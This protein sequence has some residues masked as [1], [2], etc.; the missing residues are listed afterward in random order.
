MDAQ[1]TVE[2][3]EGARESKLGQAAKL[4][5]AV[6]EP[7]DPRPED[8]S[9]PVWPT[10]PLWAW[11]RWTLLVGRK[12]SLSPPF[13][14]L[15]FPPNIELEEHFEKKFLQNSSHFSFRILIITFSY[16]LEID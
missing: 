10:H 13:K 9:G 5:Q 16:E 3:R 7:W 6:W 12:S 8:L 1:D 15:S 2:E 14:H 11:L 4:G